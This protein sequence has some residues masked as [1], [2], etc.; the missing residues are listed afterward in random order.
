VAL[1][2]IIHEQ[3]V[4]EIMQLLQQQFFDRQMKPNVEVVD[5]INYV[6]QLA[7]QLTDLGEHVSK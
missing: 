4:T 2:V 5:H 6:E 3:N 1:Y 7:N